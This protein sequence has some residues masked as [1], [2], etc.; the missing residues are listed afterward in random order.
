MKRKA[1]SG[2][3]GRKEAKRR[4]VTTHTRRGYQTVARTRGVYAQGEMKYFDSQRALS[5]IPASVDWQ[6]T[7]FDP[8][9]VPVVNMNTLFVPT[10][11]AGINQRIGKAVKLHKIRIQGQIVTPNQTADPNTDSSCLVRLALVWDTQTNS[12]QAQGEQVFAPPVTANS[13]LAVD[14]FQNIDNFG[15]FRVLK[16][17]KIVLQDPNIGVLVGPPAAVYAQGLVRKFKMVY[18]PKKPIEIRFNATNGGTVADIV[19]NSFHIYANCS[20][21]NLGPQIV[22]QARCC[23]KE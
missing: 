9:Q 6:G 11:G 18:K 12:T 1:Y 19:D 21:T 10:Q 14:S 23:F 5:A 7:E 8:N 20:N 2:Q 16:D 13:Y 4:R 3:Y 15:R 22:Y 17:K